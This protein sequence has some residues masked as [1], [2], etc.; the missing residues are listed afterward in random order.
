MFFHYER[1]ISCLEGLP[2]LFRNLPTSDS[3]IHKLAAWSIWG[4]LCNISFPVKAT[5]AEGE[6]FLGAVNDF[7]TDKSERTF[8]QQRCH[9]TWRTSCT[10]AC[11]SWAMNI[12]KAKNVVGGKIWTVFFELVSPL[13]TIKPQNCAGLRLDRNRCKIKIWFPQF[14]KIW[15]VLQTFSWSRKPKHF[16]SFDEL[17]HAIVFSLSYNMLFPRNMYLNSQICMQLYRKQKLV[18]IT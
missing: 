15:S 5:E 16:T 9:S 11:L 17:F 18:F 12:L 2:C 1:A 7:S 10:P 3:K 13:N 4:L 14:W 8:Y 6:I